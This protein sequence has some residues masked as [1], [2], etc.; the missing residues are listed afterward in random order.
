MQADN[1]STH[2][3]NH[4]PDAPKEGVAVEEVVEEA[5]EEAAEEDYLHQQDQACFLRMDEPLT[6]HS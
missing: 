1:R 2:H 4:L 3:N 5:V 6:Q